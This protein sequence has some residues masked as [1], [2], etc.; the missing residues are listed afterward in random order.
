MLF[1]HRPGLRYNDPMKHQLV[2]VTAALF[3]REG[4]VLIAK[5]SPEGKQPG[6]WEF[7]GG[8]V[9]TAETPEEALRRELA[10]EF[11]IHAVI[12][13]HRITVNHQYSEIRIK[14]ICYE[15]KEY[16]GEL[17]PL[18]HS[19]IAWVKQKELS[20]YDLADA[21]REAAEAIS[22]PAG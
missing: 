5:R 19:E 7:P 21:D 17:I 8:K 15:V 6:K 10:E 16:D 1:P 20:V 9:E 11:G 22:F 14:L 12:G 3:F 18:E 2:P 4:R 13:K